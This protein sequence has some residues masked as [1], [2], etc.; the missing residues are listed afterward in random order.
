MNALGCTDLEEFHRL[1]AL[2]SISKQIRRSHPAR[3]PEFPKFIRNVNQSRSD[4]RDLE[5]GQEQ[6]H[7]YSGEIVGLCELTW[8]AFLK[9]ADT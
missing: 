3:F 5:V 1:V 4:H 8:T 9:S 2:T 7:A 6:N